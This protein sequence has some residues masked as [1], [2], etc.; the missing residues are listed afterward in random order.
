MMKIYQIILHCAVSAS[1]VLIQNPSPVPLGG[2]AEFVCNATSSE[3]FWIHNT[4]NSSE[5]PEN[6]M[7]EN[8]RS[9]TRSVTLLVPAILVNNNTDITCQTA[10]NNSSSAKLY[11][12]G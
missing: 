7:S 2:I 1:G 11:I 12:Y 4:T 6:T 8:A 5:L 9:T 10:E 3:L